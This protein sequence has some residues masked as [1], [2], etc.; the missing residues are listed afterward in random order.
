MGVKQ[1]SSDLLVN[2]CDEFIYYEDLVRPTTAAPGLDPKLRNLPH[3]KAEALRLVLETFEALQREGKESI[4]GSMI[5][6][7]LVRK[8]PSF[9]ESYFGYPTRSEERRVGKECRSR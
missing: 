5:K 3:K 8:L 9:N 7:T 6:Q 4:Y 1:F 2:N